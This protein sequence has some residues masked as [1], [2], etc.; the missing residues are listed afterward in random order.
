M[1]SNSIHIAQQVVAQAE[2]Y[3][4]QVVQAA[5]ML[6][7]N[8]DSKDMQELFNGIYQQAST[9]KNMFVGGGLPYP[10]DEQSYY[11]AAEFSRPGVEIGVEPIGGWTVR[12]FTE[13][14]RRHLVIIGMT[15]SGK[16][17][18]LL[19]IAARLAS[20]LMNSITRPAVIIFDRHRNFSCLKKQKA[21][22]WQIKNAKECRF[23]LFAPVTDGFVRAV[24][25]MLC[26]VRG[27]IKGMNVISDAHERV[28]QALQDMGEEPPVPTLE[29]ITMALKTLKFQHTKQE[30]ILSALTELDDMLRSVGCMWNWSAA[31]TMDNLLSPGAQTVIL[32]DELDVDEELFMLTWMLRYAIDSGNIR[33][34]NH[35]VF[36]IVDELQPLFRRRWHDQRALQTIKTNLLTA[37]QPRIGLIGGLQIPSETEAELLASASTII[38]TG[39]QDRANIDV[40][41][42]AMGISRDAGQ[43]LFQSLEIN[44][45]VYRCANRPGPFCIEVPL[46]RIP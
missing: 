43:D 10:P 13:Q 18:L 32:T 1:N 2:N 42:G 12:L 11:D 37:R 46:A 40:V 9:I 5:M 41:S 44:E 35:H 23:A 26:Q 16:T 25:Q 45:A 29:H 20:I 27:L 4:S 28:T 39:L 17:N 6:L 19:L 33:V 36:F 7:F 8:P 15:G 30:Y 22:N 24:L 38:C 21:Q 34:R 31:D 3:P 14:L